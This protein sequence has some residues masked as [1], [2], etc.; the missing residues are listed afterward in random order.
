VVSPNAGVRKG[1]R[2]VRT[3]DGEV[4]AKVLVRRQKP[5]SSP[6]SN[7]AHPNLVFPVDRI[8]WIARIVWESQ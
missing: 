3:T 1:D 5:S 2:V 6:P 4:V 8:D 7:P